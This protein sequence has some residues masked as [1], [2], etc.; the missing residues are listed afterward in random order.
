MMIFIRDV[1]KNNQYGIY[2]YPIRFDSLG[3]AYSDLR[4][5]G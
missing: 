3:Y 1:E 2:E 5:V 4:S